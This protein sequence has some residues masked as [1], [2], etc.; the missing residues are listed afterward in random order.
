MVF[1][2]KE[3]LADSAR[4]VRRKKICTLG[5]FVFP[6]FALLLA[7]LRP[8]HSEASWLIDPE[9][10]HVSAHGPLSCQ[11]CHADVTGAVPHPN[12]GH[13]S[14][15][16]AD[17]SGPGPCA[18]CHADVLDQI[19]EGEHGGSKIEDRRKAA[20]C[21][22]CHDPHYEEAS[23]ASRTK[24][25]PPEPGVEKCARCHELRPALPEPSAQDALCM[26]CHR[27][28]PADDP[29]ARDRM[30]D[31]CLHCHGKPLDSALTEPWL[32]VPRLD[33]AEYP[34]SPHCKLACTVC[35]LR[36]ADYPHSGQK[37]VRCR[38]CHPLHDER[39]AHDA[40]L[41]VSCEG[42]HLKGVVPVRD[43]QSGRILWETD[44]SPDRLS[45]VH[46][47]S[48]PGNE[49]ACG[50]CHFP[51]N[52]LGA[53]GRVLPA[54]SILCMPCHVA[55]FSVA[56]TPTRA[57][58]LLFCLGLASLVPVWM[59]GTLGGRAGQS[60]G[61]KVWTVLKTVL[62]T[63]FSRTVFSIVGT[64]ILD[65]LLQR[66]LFRQSGIR[67][68]IHSLIFFP[69]VLRFLWGMSGLLASLWFPEYRLTWIL[70]DKDHPAGAFVFDVTGLMV[71]AGVVLAMIRR[72]R[73]EPGQRLPGL[74][75]PDWISYGLLAAIMIVGFVLE[76][77]R[78]SMAGSPQGAAYAFVGFGLSRFFAGVELTASYGTVWYLHAFLTAGFVA[79]LPF[80]RMFHLLMA[81][82]SLALGAASRHPEESQ[83]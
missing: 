6:A 44:R 32:L 36:S 49:E 65:G 8:W 43:I 14:K 70:L 45:E 33:M 29:Q 66:R 59:S 67:W 24:A 12:P 7:L 20:D 82:L 4:P 54:K 75:R 22:G 38:G 68:G 80:S 13:V 74:P 21:A 19:D 61:R 10:F 40:H 51:G 79:Y 31:F 72:V 64:L 73:M 15:A 11:D 1:P 23:E 30:A 56:D 18:D 71:L 2:W 76:A 25:A 16:S 34:S 39:V 28:A 55:T 50:K 57:G 46:Q 52:R 9:R 77:M 41:K 48:W 26:D 63:L 53:A 27:F 81:P 78:I 3:P 62:G 17:F 47:M 37:V 42:C 58:L 83:S 5:A 69:F 35:H 60:R